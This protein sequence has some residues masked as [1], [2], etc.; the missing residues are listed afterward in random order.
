ME[1]SNIY[2]VGE[3]VFEYLNPF[4][5]LYI[6]IQVRAMVRGNRYF[7]SFRAGAIF[8]EDTCSS[9]NEEGIVQI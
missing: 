3:E 2:Y 8:F 9:D 6:N 4:Y 7:T 5:T 1:T